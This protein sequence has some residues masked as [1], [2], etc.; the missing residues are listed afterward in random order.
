[1]GPDSDVTGDRRSQ[2]DRGKRATVSRQEESL[3]E[4]LLFED[5]LE[6]RFGPARRSD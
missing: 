6:R 4:V 1:M 2:Q 5:A 3:R